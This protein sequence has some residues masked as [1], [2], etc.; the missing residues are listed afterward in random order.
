VSVAT[1]ARHPECLRALAFSDLEGQ[2]WGAAWLPP[3][4]AETAVISANNQTTS[5]PASLDGEEASEPWRLQLEEGNLVLKGQGDP[6]EDSDEPHTGFD[7]LCRVSGRMSVG[8]QPREVSCLGWRAARSP[9]ILTTDV[10][11]LRQ[12]AAWFGPDDG[13]ALLALR[14][15]RAKGQ[16]AEAV[17]AAMFDA[18]DPQAVVEPRLSTTYDESGEAL[19]AGVE[20]WIHTDEDPEQQY[21][22]RAIGERV[23]GPARWTVDELAIEAQPFHW[24]AGAREGA[25]VYLLARRS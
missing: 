13:F 23:Q 25:G 9:S 11:S 8:G 19:R 15:A 3:G 4:S 7:Q 16:D 2:L 5:V 6:I 12:V 18:D 24:Y 17:S 14:P 20:L 10:A 21:P 1:R 22:R